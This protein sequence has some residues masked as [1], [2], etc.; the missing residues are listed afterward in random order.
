MKHAIYE[1]MTK[2]FP[3]FYHSLLDN[4]SMALLVLSL[5]PTG[6]GTPRQVCGVFRGGHGLL[7]GLG[8]HDWV[9]GGSGM[10]I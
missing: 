10:K 1:T 6:L 4:N 3:W 8:P 9:N 5:I 7:H 2:L